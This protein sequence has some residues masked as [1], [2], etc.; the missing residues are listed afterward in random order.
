M[1]EPHAIT[2]RASIIGHELGTSTGLLEWFLSQK[3]QCRGFTHAIFSGLPTVVLAAI[4]RDIIVPRS[5]LTGI[6]HVAAKPISKFDL[7]TLIAE[8]YR[9][10]IDIIPEAKPVIDRSLI[11][12]KFRNR[13]GY[14]APGWSQLVQTMYSHR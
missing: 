4:I 13:T 3:A 14:S 11:A 9:K 2:I 12:D 1:R 8:I 10:R 6:Y 5:E 7:L